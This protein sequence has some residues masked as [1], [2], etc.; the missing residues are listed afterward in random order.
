MTMEIKKHYE[1]LKKIGFIDQQALKGNN[2]YEDLLCRRALF[3]GLGRVVR[4]Y[5]DYGLIICIGKGWKFK[6]LPSW[7]IKK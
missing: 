7:V 4:H 3:Q 6:N 1:H 2:W 5:K